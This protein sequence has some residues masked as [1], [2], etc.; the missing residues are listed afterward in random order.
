MSTG[1]RR[2]YRCGESGHLQADCQQQSEVGGGRGGL[3]GDRRPHLP[4][5]VAARRELSR[6]NESLVDVVSGYKRLH[7][8]ERAAKRQRFQSTA[9]EGNQQA[10]QSG[11]RVGGQ[12]AERAVE[13]RQE[14]APP[15]VQAAAVPAPVEPPQEATAD[16]ADSG[17]RKFTEASI[18]FR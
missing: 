7:Y 6:I 4:P 3:R 15:V 17:D 10:A 18:S 12:L 14:V 2:C 5:H 11:D 8:F 16:S 13:L 9:S 1:S